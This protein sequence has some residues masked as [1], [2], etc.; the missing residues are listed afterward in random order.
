[1]IQ[2]FI[3]ELIEWESLDKLVIPPDEDHPK[4]KNTA[5]F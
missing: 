3:K 2:S 1:M 5:H 4:W